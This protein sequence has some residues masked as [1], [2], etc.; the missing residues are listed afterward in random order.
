MPTDKVTR[1]V[2]ALGSLEELTEHLLHTKYSLAEDD[3]PPA[4]EE[5]AKGVSAIGDAIA[6][7]QD[8]LAE[9]SFH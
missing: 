4:V 9:Q 7:L 1:L 3:C 6:R 5:M 8:E 2:E